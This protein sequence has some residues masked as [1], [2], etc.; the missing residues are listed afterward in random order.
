[1]I[2]RVITFI[3]HIYKS[4]GQRAYLITPLARS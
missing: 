1:M 2:E 3:R 4:C